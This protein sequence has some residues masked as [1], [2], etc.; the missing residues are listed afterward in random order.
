MKLVI[1]ADE[2]ALELKQILLEHLRGKGLEVVDLAYLAQAKA[3][4]PDIAFQLA[5]QVQTGEFTR[6]I[7]LCGTGLGMAM[8]AN[9]VQG[10]FAGTCHDVYSAERLC[11]SNDAQIITMGA[12]VIG[13]ELAKTIIDAWLASDFQGGSSTSK[14]QRMRTLEMES[15]IN[16]GDKTHTKACG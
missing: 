8:C 3:D 2:A 16:C 13:P 14:V 6:G 1:D 15:F 10:V 11:K 5:Q 12:R 7:L 4:Y 9:K